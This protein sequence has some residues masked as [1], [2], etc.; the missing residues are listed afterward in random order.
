MGQDIATQR[1]NDVTRARRASGQPT[2]AAAYA[3]ASSGRR[4]SWPGH[5]CLPDF[6]ICIV[7]SSCNH[8]LS[9]RGEGQVGDIRALVHA[10]QRPCNIRRW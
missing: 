6:Y 10:C 8:F 3:A 7:A 1:A 9:F 2:D 5:G 4:T